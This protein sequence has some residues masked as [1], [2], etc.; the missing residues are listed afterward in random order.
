M[1]L[2]Q[3]KFGYGHISGVVL[4]LAKKTKAMQIFSSETAS[5]EASN[6]LNAPSAAVAP[7]PLRNPRRLRP[8]EHPQHAC[9]TDP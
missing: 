6:G 8:G 9:E 1:R 4:L 7:H 3:S 2:A 5:L